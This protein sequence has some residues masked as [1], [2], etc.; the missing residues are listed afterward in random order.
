[1]A[2]PNDGRIEKGDDIL[3]EEANMKMDE[4]TWKTVQQHLGYND[5]E[6]RRL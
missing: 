5:E 4:R 1:M 6:N 2:C 3:G